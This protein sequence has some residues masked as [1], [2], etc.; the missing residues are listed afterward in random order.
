MDNIW[1]V[2]L[3]G[4]PMDINKEEKWEQEFNNQI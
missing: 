3:T 1:P 4:W 2:R